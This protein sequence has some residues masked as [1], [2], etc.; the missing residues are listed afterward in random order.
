MAAI[1]RDLHRPG[2]LPVGQLKRESRYLNHKVEYA[3][4]GPDTLNEE[5]DTVPPDP[6][7]KEEIR[8]IRVRG[9]NGISWRITDLSGKN[10][11]GYQVEKLHPVTDQVESGGRFVTGLNGSPSSEIYYWGKTEGEAPRRVTERSTGTAVENGERLIAEF[12]QS[13]RQKKQQ[14][15]AAA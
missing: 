6:R 10:V 12:D 9:Q 2:I 13:L 15:Q 11:R 7:P 4:L 3:L 1:E 5:R 8:T 14:I